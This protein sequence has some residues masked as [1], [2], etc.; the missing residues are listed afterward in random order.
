MELSDT[1]FRN[2][3]ITMKKSTLTASLLE[4]F[5]WERIAP[6]RFSHMGLPTAY[7]APDVRPTRSAPPPGSVRRA[8]QESTGGPTTWD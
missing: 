1:P 7:R 2:K 4:V 3:E 6:E 5:P 8:S